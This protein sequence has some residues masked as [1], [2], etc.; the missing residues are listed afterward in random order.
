LR[1]LLDTHALLWSVL[2]APEL[3]RR[4]R[5]ALANPGNDV[6]VSAVSIFEITLKHRLG[7]LRQAAPFALHHDRMLAD[8]AWEPLPVSFAHASLAG[9]LDIPHKDPFDRLLVAQ[10][11]LERVPLVSNEALFDGFG[12][13]RLW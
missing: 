5:E 7:K 4:A 6:L 10:A 3:S 11:R 2:D 13:E 12:V 8:L 9:F 1:L